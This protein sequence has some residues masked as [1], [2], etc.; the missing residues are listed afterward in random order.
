M[1]FDF[2]DVQNMLDDLRDEGYLTESMYEYACDILSDRR[3]DIQYD[4]YDFSDDDDGA[5]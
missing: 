4:D 5:F 2:D 1:S 3:A